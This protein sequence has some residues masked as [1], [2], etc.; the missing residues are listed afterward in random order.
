MSEWKQTVAVSDVPQEGTLL[1]QVASEPVCLYNL[2]GRIYATHD[3]CT[4]MTASLSDGW[5]IGENIECPMHNGQFHIPTGNAAVSPCVGRLRTYP[6]KIVDGMV[7][8]DASHA[9]AI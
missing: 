4:H 7:L 3:T 8:I 9:I 2:Q 1:I 6:I 5:V